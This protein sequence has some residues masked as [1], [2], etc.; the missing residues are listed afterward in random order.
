MADL[1]TGIRGGGGG[2]LGGGNRFVDPGY[3][4]EPL[5]ESYSTPDKEQCDK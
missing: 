2:G 3:E 4:C 5:E 1:L